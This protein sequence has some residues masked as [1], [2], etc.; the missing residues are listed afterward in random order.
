MAIIKYFDEKKEFSRMEDCAEKAWLAVSR[1]ENPY[2]LSREDHMMYRDWL[3]KTAPATVEEFIDKNRLEAFPLLIKYRTIRK[4]NINRFV[5]MAREKRKMDILSFLMNATNEFRTRPK[6]M[7]IAPKF[8][9][10]K[11]ETDFA[12]KQPDGNTKPGRLVWLG[13]NPMPWQVLENKDG[14]LLLISYYAFDCQ[15]YN[16]TYYKRCW[17]DS[18]L[19]K[20]LNGEFVRGYFSREEKDKILPVHID[21]GD[22]LYNLP[23]ENTRENL[24]FLLSEEEA[25]KYYPDEKSRRARVTVV[26]RGRILWQSFGTYAHW[27]LR[28]ASLDEVGQSHVLYNGAVSRYGGVMESNS[29]ARYYDHFGVRPAMY[30]KL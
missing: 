24:M 4:A 14:R 17:N 5:D 26:G 30:Y 7:D 21:D 28:T 23:Q 16:N 19:N 27:W 6:A 12:H 10:G 15:A 3:N 9:P 20:W 22:N 2:N 29:F 11:S 1:L 25:V 13:K 8:T 18:A